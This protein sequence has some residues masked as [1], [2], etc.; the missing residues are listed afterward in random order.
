MVFD[1]EGFQTVLTREKELEEEKALYR[2]D[3]LETVKKI[4]EQFN[5]TA[6]ELG[7][8]T[9]GA[10]SKEKTKR[11]VAP[12]YR[13]PDGEIWTGRGRQPKAITEAIAAGH[14]LESMLIK[15]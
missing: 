10:P 11:I 3:A 2:E 5:F 12:K 6:A 15:D 9:D 7:I 1:F 13:T 14:S 8:T 4:M